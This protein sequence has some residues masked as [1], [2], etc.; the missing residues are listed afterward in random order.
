M[1]P[2][3]S[4]QIFAYSFRFVVIYSVYLIEISSLTQLGSCLLLV[5]RFF[6]TRVL[7]FYFFFCMFDLFKFFFPMFLNHTVSMVITPADWILLVRPVLVE[8]FSIKIPLT[9]S[10]SHRI[11]TN[12][13]KR[14]QLKKAFGQ[15]KT[16]AIFHRITTLTFKAMVLKPFT[17]WHLQ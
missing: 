5:W 15:M 17:M 12:R 1:F 13:P 8:F 10:E 9:P 3:S 16:S 7:F 6:Y 14:E 2:H 11:R 4:K